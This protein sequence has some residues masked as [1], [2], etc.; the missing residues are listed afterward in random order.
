M[1]ADE[2]EDADAPDAD[3]DEDVAAADDDDDDDG[4]EEEEE[5]VACRGTDTHPGNEIMLC[6]GDG[7]ER[8]WHQLCLRPALI[9]VP[10]DVSW[11]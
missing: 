7:C 11:H 5:C 9:D 1:D 10:E 6:D 8:A 2:A 4:E 3:A